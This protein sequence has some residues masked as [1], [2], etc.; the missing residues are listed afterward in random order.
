MSHRNA[1]LALVV[2]LA[3]G[4]FAAPWATQ[5]LAADAAPTVALVP[6]TL[7][8]TRSIPDG[9]K[10]TC[11]VGPG[12]PVSSGTCPV[13]QWKGYTYWAY[14]F[15]VN[16]MDMA[17]V[18]YDGAGNIV[19][20]WDRHGDRY[21]W[22]ITVDASA[23]TVTFK[24]Q[25]GAIVM[26]W[27]E[28]ALPDLTPVDTTPPSIAPPTFPAGP[29]LLNGSYAAPTANATDAG[30]GIATTSCDA[31]DTS[32]VGTK[33]V[34]CSATDN[35]GNTVSGTFS[36]TVGYEVA[37]LYDKNKSY[38]LGSIAPLKVQLRDANGNN[39]SA[40]G[41]VVSAGAAAKQDGS[42]SSV[43]A[44]DAGNANPDSNF[45][46]DP[47]LGGTGGYIYNFQTK[48]FSSGTWQLSFAVNG[49]TNPA[50]TITFDV[51]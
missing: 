16:S 9:L 18:A 7:A 29:F 28:L 20:R 8:S 13:L 30:S 41:I 27:A 6:N 21:V 48:G 51:R 42:A 50:Y 19:R 2:A 44:S 35:A 10:Q 38:K 17:I 31:L 11:L 5:T 49:A 22:D 45:R 43:L 46:Y 12:G 33:Q 24:G 47:T 36:Y 15:H 3:L 23:E 14:S 32:S 1:V 34:T 40:A 26:T 37:L 4:L 25:S 39:V